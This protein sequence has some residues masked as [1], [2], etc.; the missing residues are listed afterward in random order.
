MALPPTIPTSFVPR[1]DAPHRFRTDL[2]GAFG[3]FAYAILGIVFLLAIGIF[4]YGRIL[5]NEQ[6]AKDTQLAAAQNAIDTKTAESFLRL[7]DRLLSANTL[8][9]DHVAFSA[10][11]STMEKIIPSTVRFT[12]LHLLLDVNGATRLEAAG[13]AKS[14]NAL[15]SASTAF[16]TDGRI[17]DA[18]FSGI[19]VNHDNSVNFMLAATLD[20]ELTTYT[21]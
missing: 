11:F 8:L 18:I 9:N 4:I 17:K 10:F 19:K 1:P 6:K 13:L 7:R 20:P 5:T 16:A 14:F 3:F 21:P 15:A 2:T 12:S